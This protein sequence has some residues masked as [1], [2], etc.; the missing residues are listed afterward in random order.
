MSSYL[1]G[2]NFVKNSRQV[3]QNLLDV[4]KVGHVS[5]SC[6]TG[7][8]PDREETLDVTEAGEGAVRS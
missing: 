4:L 1:L 2:V 5:R 8:C 6:D 3:A 7:R